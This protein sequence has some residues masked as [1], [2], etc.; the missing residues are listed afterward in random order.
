[1]STPVVLAVILATACALGGIAILVELR[2]A[3]LLVRSS[4]A[5]SRATAQPDWLTRT[6]GG[7]ARGTLL[8]EEELLRWIPDPRWANSL[9]EMSWRRDQIRRIRSRRY[10][11]WHGVLIED[12]DG[13]RAGLIVR[14]RELRAAVLRAAS[15][16][17]GQRAAV[18]DAID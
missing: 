13:G 10:F 17:S 7:V 5:G 9:R 12:S 8:V 4:L 1:M 16:Q 2:S 14:E 6:P 3:V 15:E 18:D 11:G